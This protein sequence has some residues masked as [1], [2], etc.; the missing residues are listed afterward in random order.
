M[1]AIAVAAALASACLFA[2][3]N[4]LQH[5]AASSDSTNGLRTGRLL[6]ALVARPSWHAGVVLGALAFTL[7]GVAV[8]NGPLIVVQPLVVTGIVL[9]VP[10]RAA[11]DRKRPAAEDMRWVAVTAAGIALFVISSNPTSGG[12]DPRISCVGPMVVGG[13]IF[14]ATI[15]RAGL[16]MESERGRGLVL[17]CASGIL[18]GLNAGVLKLAV[19]YA[20][21][22]WFGAFVLAT[23]AAVGSCAFVLNQKT[24]QVAPLATSMPVLNVAVV[25]VASSFG[26]VVFRENP[27]HDV[28]GL[29]CELAGLLVMGFGLAN[30]AG[31]SERPSRP[32]SSRT[33]TL[34]RLSIGVA[35][36]GPH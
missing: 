26:F 12:G 28:Q 3:S 10:F 4:S 7:H 24:Y 8:G 9:A 23:L 6:M 18:M 25:L 5:R 33:A 17:G 13:G 11:L 1:M 34:R 2:L 29:V 15:A 19:L 35:S 27:A 36:P 14:A 22:R 16:R 32:R 31:R 30:L 21:D 20:T